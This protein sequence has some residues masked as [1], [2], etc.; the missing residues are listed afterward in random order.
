MTT[1]LQKHF[2]MI[3]DRREI[4]AE[5]H[6]KKYLQEIFD[7]WTEDEQ[8]EF[9]DFCTGVRGVKLLYDAFFKELMNPEYV[10]ER[11][12]D[13]LSVLMQEKVHIVE[14]M[15]G[16]SSR[17]ADERSLLVMDILVTLEDGS[18][19]NIEV[20][21]IGYLFP[22]ERC[23]CY[24]ADLLLR[25]YKRVRGNS[26]RKNVYKDLKAVYTI[27]L[28]ESSPREFHRFKKTY[29]HHFSQKS[30][31]GLELNLL[32]KYLFIPL[33][34]FRE[35]I[36]NKD[37]EN[38]LEAWL[39]FFCEDSPDQIIRLIEKYPEFKP[40]YEHVYDMCLNVEKVME[41][42]SKELLE[43]DRNTV[44]YM[45]DEMQAEINQQRKQLEEQEA[46]ISKLKAALKKQHLETV[47]K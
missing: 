20:Q 7:K 40:L 11:L 8:S 13:F 19:C 5:I 4:T 2:P 30:D 1:K 31:S 44:Q 3:R 26:N 27:V 6:S 14:V 43:L 46:E 24:S 33:D 45:M 23:A 36:H 21:K 41:M 9:L 10:P 38:K 35:I 39:A 37:I 22:G 42:Y 16:D 12:D 28:F 17:I 34:I 18:L 47:E 15:P 29:L 25:Q 32:Q